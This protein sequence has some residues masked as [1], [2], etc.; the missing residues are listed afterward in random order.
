MLDARRNEFM[1]RP[2][3]APGKNQ[4]PTDLR[5][6]AAHETQQFNLLVGARRKIGVTTFGRN[7][8]IAS[9]FPKQNPFAQSSSG[10]KQRART[11]LHGSA[12]IQYAEILGRQMFQAVTGRA[13]VVHQNDG[14]DGKLSR[15]SI[16]VDNPGKIRGMNTIVDDGPRD[17]ETNSRHFLV[18]KIRSSLA[19]EFF[20]DQVELGKFLA[21]KTL[22]INELELA[23]LLGK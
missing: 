3:T 14:F 2:K 7:D 23:I 12:L 11:T 21:G 22:T 1:Q 16:R 19:G 15:Q 20:D 6:A 18:V 4:F 5:V 9:A 10:G 17:A 13:Q 8:L